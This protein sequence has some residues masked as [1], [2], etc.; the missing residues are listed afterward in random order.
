MDT[1]QYSLR[2]PEEMRDGADDSVG[3]SMQAALRHAQ[4]IEE[5]NHNHCSQGNRKA[6]IDD[7]LNRMRGILKDIKDTDWMYEDDTTGS[8]L[9]LA[10][11]NSTTRNGYKRDKDAPQPLG[12]GNLQ[13]RHF[14]LGRRQALND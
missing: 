8:G 14:S 7:G 11:D 5:S 4:V 12:R 1:S 10:G 2:V 13:E 9:V 6:L 3:H